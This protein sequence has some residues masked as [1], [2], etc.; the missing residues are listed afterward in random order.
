LT[1]E[2]GNQL[3]T[4]DG[5]IVSITVKG[6]ELSI[7]SRPDLEGMGTPKFASSSLGDDEARTLEV[8]EE[9]EDDEEPE[10]GRRQAHA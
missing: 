5:D 8:L 3:I 6:D 4:R 7:D 1:H 2:R 9:V 10:A